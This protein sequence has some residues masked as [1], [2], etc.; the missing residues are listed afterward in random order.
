VG[1]AVDKGGC[2]GK[3]QHTTGKSYFFST[4]WQKVFDMNF[5]QTVFNGLFELPLLR[6]AQKRHRKKITKKKVRYLPT[7]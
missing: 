1:L 5:P 2:H 6:N 7:P 3:G 4:F